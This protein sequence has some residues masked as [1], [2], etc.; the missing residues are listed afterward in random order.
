[1]LARVQV[2]MQEI[3]AELERRDEQLREMAVHLSNEAELRSSVDRRASELERELQSVRDVLA[4]H[5]ICFVL[6]FH[7]V[8]HS[9][10]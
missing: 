8:V 3:A 7:L 1:M 4:V 6:F 10:S 9:N 5:T 2:Q